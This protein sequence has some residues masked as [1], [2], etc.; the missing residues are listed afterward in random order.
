MDRKDEYCDRSKC[1]YGSP[2]LQNMNGDQVVDYLPQQQKD[3]EQISCLR[4]YRNT[5]QE[6]CLNSSIQGL[7]QVAEPQPYTIRR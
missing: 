1:V 7:K 5:L 6:F 4:T 2:E 3:A